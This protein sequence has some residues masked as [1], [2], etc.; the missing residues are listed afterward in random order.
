[1]NDDTLFMIEIIVVG[2]L[3]IALGIGISIMR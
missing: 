3:I 1:M 2:L